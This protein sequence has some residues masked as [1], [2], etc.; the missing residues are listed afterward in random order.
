MVSGCQRSSKVR[1]QG[2]EEAR[3]SRCRSGVK[4]KTTGRVENDRHHVGQMGTFL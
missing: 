2:R 3:Y 4:W 1:Q